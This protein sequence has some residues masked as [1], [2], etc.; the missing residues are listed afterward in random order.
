MSATNDD[1]KRL[2]E[3]MNAKVENLARVVGEESDDGKS[4]TGL[5]G[6]VR[7]ATQQVA[8]LKSLRDQGLGLLLGVLIVA[9]VLGLGVKQAITTMIGVLK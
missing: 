9:A 1:L 2:L 5:F 8:A 6:E 3:G 7:R 4:G